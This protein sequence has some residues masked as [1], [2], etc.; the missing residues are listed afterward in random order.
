MSRYKRDQEYA[1]TPLVGRLQ[2]PATLS[3]DAT[4]SEAVQIVIGLLHKHIPASRSKSAAITKFEEGLLWARQ[5]IT[6]PA[7]HKEDA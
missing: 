7:N 2:D 6:D 4:I 1:F 5:G 3:A